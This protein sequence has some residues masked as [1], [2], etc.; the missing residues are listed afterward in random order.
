MPRFG[1]LPAIAALFFGLKAAVL[2]IVLQA[3]QRVGAR[4]L[5]SSAMRAIAGAAFVGIFF[6]AIPFPLIILAAALIGFVGA[7]AGSSAFKIGGG[8]GGGGKQVL[9]DADSLLGDQLAR[10]CAS[11]HC[12][13]AARRGHLVGT[14]ARAGRSDRR[15]FRSRQRL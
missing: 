1:H 7:R 14:V 8:H 9:S 2:A 11:D 4:A 13:R 3:V 12:A 15:L 6:F 10:S 5:K